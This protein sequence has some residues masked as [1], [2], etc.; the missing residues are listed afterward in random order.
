[1]QACLP[2]NPQTSPLK[3]KQAYVESNYIKSGTPQHSRGGGARI[4]SLYTGRIKLVVVPNEAALKAKADS[5]Y[6]GEKRYYEEGDTL[7]L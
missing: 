5:M 1:M 6:E 3:F 2:Q 7:G 4:L